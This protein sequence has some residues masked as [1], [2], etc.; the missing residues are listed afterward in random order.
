MITWFYEAFWKTGID[1]DGLTRVTPQTDQITTIFKWSIC[2]Q[3][4]HQSQRLLKRKHTSVCPKWQKNRLSRTDLLDNNSYH[5]NFRDRNNR[6]PWGGLCNAQGQKG[7]VT[8]PVWWNRHSNYDI[9]H[10]LNMQCHRKLWRTL[11][12]CNILISRPSHIIWC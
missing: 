5:R 7:T 4:K 1:H 6:F 3:E 11:S 8:K 12:Y 2:K 9:L 10:V